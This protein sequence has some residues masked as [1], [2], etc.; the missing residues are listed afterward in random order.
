MTAK[1][2][3]AILSALQNG[4]VIRRHWKGANVGYLSHRLDGI[5]NLRESECDELRR[6]GLL[7]FTGNSGRRIFYDLRLKS[8]AKVDADNGIRAEG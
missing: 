2:R 6:E 4:A 1:R 3:A 5:K 8:D 7:E